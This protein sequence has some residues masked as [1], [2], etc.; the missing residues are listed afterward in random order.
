[1]APNHWPEPWPSI[2]DTLTDVA[3]TLDQANIPAVTSGTVEELARRLDLT[4]RATT[5]LNDIAEQLEQALIDAMPEDAMAIN[6]VG[7][8][9]RSERQPRMIWRDEESAGRLRDDLSGA[10]AREIAF[11]V[12]TG[13]IDPIKRNIATVAA[14]AALDAVGKTGLNSVLTGA[15]R[16]YNVWMNEYKER[17]AAGYRV[18]IETPTGEPQ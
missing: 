5:L 16:R 14:Q 13:E 15:Q 11:D 9:M 12:G 17:Q 18:K 8:L 10:I 6:G 4:L 7:V 2:D 1:M 3:T